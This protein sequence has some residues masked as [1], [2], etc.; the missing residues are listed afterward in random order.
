MAEI[1]SIAGNI[2]SIDLGPN[3]PSAVKKLRNAIKRPPATSAGIIG[4]KISDS[5]LINAMIG[6]NFLP[7][8]AICF[9]SSVETSE[10]PVSLINSS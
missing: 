2:S 4:T 6:L 5:N 1:P 9:K 8:L 7:L 10:S 3:N